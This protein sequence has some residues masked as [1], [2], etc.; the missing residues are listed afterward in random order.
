[1]QIAPTTYPSVPTVAPVENTCKASQ[2]STTIRFHQLSFTKHTEYELHTAQY[3]WMQTLW[4]NDDL[5]DTIV[6]SECLEWNTC[7]VMDIHM[8]HVFNDTTDMD[9]Y[10][11]LVENGQTYQGQFS[12]IFRHAPHVDVCTVKRSIYNIYIKK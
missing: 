1:M 7:Y 12:V 2:A 9:T 10:W 4:F 11:I 5:Y 3:D 6:I 8:D